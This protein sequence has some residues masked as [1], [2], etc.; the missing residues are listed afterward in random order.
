MNKTLVHFFIILLC[1]CVSSSKLHSQTSCAEV[2]QSVGIDHYYFSVSYMGGG[3]AFFD[4]DNDGDEDIWITG[5][6]NQDVLYENTEGQFLETGTAAGL[7]NTNGHIT[8]GVITADLDNDGFRDVIVLGHIG[9]HP[10]L[11]RNNGNGT[12]S[13]IS[14]SAGLSEYEGQS[15]A[16]TCGDINQDGFLDIYV[17]TYIDEIQ[18]LYNGSGEVV[19][20]DHEC[21][22]NFL[23]INNGDWTFS[24]MA[25]EY[26]VRNGGCA[27]ATTFT[28]FDQ[29]ADADLMIANDFGQW[30][31]P[32]ALYQNQNSSTVMPNIAQSTGM[33]IGIYGMGI[34][35]GDYDRDLDLDYYVTNLGRNVLLENQNTTFTDMTTERDVEDTGTDSL[36]NTGWGTAFIDMDNDLDLDLFVC[37]GYVPSALFINNNPLNRNALFINNGNPD[38]NGTIFTESAFAAGLDDPGRGRGFAYSDYDNDG[39]LD[40]LVVNVNKQ[41]TPDTIEKVRLFR[42]DLD[43]NKH[44][45]KIKLQGTNVNR[46]AFGS[47]IKIV[48]GEHSWIHDYNGGYGTHTSQHSS[49]AHFGLGDF[50]MVD[51]LII[52]WPGGFQEQFTSIEADQLLTIVENDGVLGTNEFSDKTISLSASPN[53]FY[54]STEIEI[55]LEQ[56]EEVTL[57][58][59]NTLGQQTEVLFQGQLSAGTHAVHWNPKNKAAWNFIQ[60]KTGTKIK[61]LKII[62][63]K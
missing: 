33:D 26:E 57:S 45:L 20:F 59:F 48:V 27:L 58:I 25:A 43:I 4:Y 38:G 10:L 19:G 5:G 47:T 13:E 52:T 56:S 60:L 55:Q 7:A 6:I 29:D 8:S 54:E 31:T 51:S 21:F 36:L 46:D 49:I 16:A 42:N 14:E 18:L 9:F 50:E 23:F 53:P 40:I 39:D 35:V 22:N 15:F 1:Y 32:N 2:S 30:I 61:T 3:A 11:F 62:Q 17:T 12:F 63:F 34:A 24:E 41:T 37:N 28:D 44:W